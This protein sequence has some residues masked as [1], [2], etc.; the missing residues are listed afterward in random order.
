MESEKCDV[1]MSDSGDRVNCGPPNLLKNIFGG[2]VGA[3]LLLKLVLELLHYVEFSELM[4]VVTA[5][6]PGEPLRHSVLLVNLSGEFMTLWVVCWLS[7][8]WYLVNC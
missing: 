2:L 6:A 5:L 7:L 3:V 1:Y 4:L 8:R